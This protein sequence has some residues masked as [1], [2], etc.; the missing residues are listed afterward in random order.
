[1][2]YPLFITLLF[3]LSPVLSFPFVLY[4]LLTSKKYGM[5]FGVLFACAAGLFVYTLIPDSDMDI[6][7]YYDYMDRLNMYSF[8][9]AMQAIW[10]SNDPAS[11]SLMYLLS[12][13][14]SKNFIPLVF[15]IL[16]YSSL[17]YVI[18]DYRKN[19][20][21]RYDWRTSFVLFFIVATIIIFNTLTGLRFALALS[22]LFLALYLDIFKRRKRLAIWLYALSPLIHSSAVLVILLRVASGIFKKRGTTIFFVGSAV[23][24]SATNLLAAFSGELAQL[25][26][27]SHVGER[28]TYYLEPNIPPGFLYPFSI[29]SSCLIVLVIMVAHIGK[30]DRLTI[31]EKMTISTVIIALVNFNQFVIGFRFATIAKYLFILVLIDIFR[32]YYSDGKIPQPPRQQLVVFTSIALIIAG[33]LAYQ[34]IAFTGVDAQFTWFYPDVFFENVFTLMAGK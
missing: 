23:V 10:S 12:Q 9:N 31:L 18:F 30:K 19:I 6:Y 7:R 1:M 2:A 16:G 25:P 33:S 24:G 8:G 34:V 28:A 13:T 29:L 11:Y 17:F 3:I 4:G 32:R 5:W 14:L 21:K 22:V 15:S 26:F 20:L 27:L